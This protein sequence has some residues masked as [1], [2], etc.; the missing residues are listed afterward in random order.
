[1]CASVPSRR[2]TRIASSGFGSWKSDSA[3]CGEAWPG[4]VGTQYTPSS[5]NSA[6]H[7]AKRRSS[8]SRASCS[9]KASSSALIACA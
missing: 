6:S 8:S 1:M 2:A 5:A 3:S 4:S 9:T 7:S